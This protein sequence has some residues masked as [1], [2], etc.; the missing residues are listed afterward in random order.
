M[1]RPEEKRAILK[2]V[3][4]KMIKEHGK[5]LSLNEIVI[6]LCESYLKDLKITKEQE[7]KILLAAQIAKISPLQV[8]GKACDWASKFY[9][10]KY[11]NSEI[12][13]RSLKERPLSPGTAYW[14]IDS[15]VKKVMKN[16]DHAK[17]SHN[18]VFINQTYL[19]KNQGSNR[20]AIKGYLEHNK[21][22]IKRH[23]RK[24]KLHAR[25]NIEV[26]APFIKQKGMDKEE[27]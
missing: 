25:H 5:E 13:G 26:N 23:H 11:K 2:K 19:A 24:H 18:K 21:E 6:I 20:S 9:T 15:F 27:L 16:N 10:K 1:N 12:K 7:Q 3:Q 8:M 17:D 14:R 22:E 4:I